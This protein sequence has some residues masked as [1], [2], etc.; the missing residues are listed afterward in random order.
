MVTHGRKGIKKAFPWVY[1]NTH[2]APR[3]RTPH[4]WSMDVRG[5]KRAWLQYK[6]RHP[7]SNPSQYGNRRS[8][9]KKDKNVEGK[10]RKY[11]TSTE[12]GNTVLVEARKKAYELFKEI[13]D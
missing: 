11:Y 13:K 7:L 4:L 3:K 5:T 8:F 12:K 9:K 2:F 6:Y 1:T 10:I